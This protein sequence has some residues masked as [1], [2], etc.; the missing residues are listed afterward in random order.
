M[1]EYKHTNAYSYIA[2]FI[3]DNI[4]KIAHIINHV[5]KFNMF[6]PSFNTVIFEST[7]RSFPVVRTY[8][9]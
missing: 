9:T 4:C 6:R 8:E 7:P 3:F 2:T 1:P 5:Q